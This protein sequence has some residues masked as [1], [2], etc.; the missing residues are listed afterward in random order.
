M[1]SRVLR[2]TTLAAVVLAGAAMPMP[3]DSVFGIRGLGLLGRPV[4]ARAAGTGGGFA[5]LD[6]PTPMNPS[7]FG[8]WRGPAGWAVGAPSRRVFDDG[9]TST[10]LGS[11]RFPLFGFASPVNARLVLAVTASDFLDR[12]WAVHTTRDTVLRSDTVTFDDEASSVGGV[13]DLRLAAAYKVTD[14]VLVGLGL[15]ALS[16]STRQ[17]V[18]R[19]FSDVGYLSFT[20][21]TV[22]DFAGAG[23]SLGVQVLASSRLAVAGTMRLNGRLKAASTGG[24]RARVAM[25]AEFAGGFVYAPVVGVGIAATVTYQTWARAAD[26]LVAAGQPRSRNVWSAAIGGE[27]E[28][29]HVRGEAVPVRIGVRQRQLPFP[30]DGADLAERAVSGGLGYTVAAGRATVDVGFEVGSRRTSTASERFTTGFV[31]ILVRP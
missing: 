16:G 5:L 11:T 10:S 29:L 23:L 24:A 21:L 31:G 15:H 18:V 19:Q 20:D 13:T 7:A 30:V 3:A 14:K 25:P 8:L 26:A 27:F 9:V 6:G 2:A 22:T 28:L 12:T 1:R 4:S 17:S